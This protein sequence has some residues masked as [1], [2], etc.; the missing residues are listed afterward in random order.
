MCRAAGR[1]ARSLCASQPL[2]AS[3]SLSPA[4]ARLSE[5]L[6][7]MRQFAKQAAAEGEQEVP[8]P[9]MTAQGD[10]E[11]SCEGIGQPASW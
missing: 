5:I 3:P 1:L 9:S 6:E 4:R 8:L 11:T 7:E 10:V 2:D